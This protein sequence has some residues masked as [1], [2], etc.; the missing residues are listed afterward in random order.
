IVAVDQ[1]IRVFDRRWHTVLH[2]FL[3]SRDVPSKRRDLDDLRAKLDVCQTEAPS[4]DPAVTE[5]LLHLVRVRRRTDVEILRAADDQEVADASAD[6]I[7]RVVELAQPIK[8]PQCVRVDVA[9][10][11]WVLGARD[12]PWLDH[13]LAI[14]PNRQLTGAKHLYINTLSTFLKPGMC[15]T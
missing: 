10:R 15:G 4:D 5:Q 7:R 9:A 3:A 1:V 12:D 11:Q 6:Q 2:D 14:V 8:H 13:R